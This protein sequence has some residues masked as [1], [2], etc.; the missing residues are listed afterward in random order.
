M[1]FKGSDQL[2]PSF[3]SGASGRTKKGYKKQETR[4]KE[5]GKDS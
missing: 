1:G 2:V 4:R 5:H 3:I